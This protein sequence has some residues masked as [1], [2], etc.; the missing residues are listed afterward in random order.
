M[1]GRTI[2]LRGKSAFEA[3][4]AAG[5]SGQRGLRRCHAQQ[6]NERYGLEEFQ[7]F[8]ILELVPGFP[9]CQ[10]STMCFRL[11]RSIVTRSIKRIGNKRKNSP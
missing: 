11:T 10:F 8:H 1:A 7:Y 5:A 4:G 3:G 6:H 2:F 9:G